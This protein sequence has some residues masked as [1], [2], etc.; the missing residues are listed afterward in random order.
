MLDGS[1]LISLAREVLS[2]LGNRAEPMDYLEDP[3]DDE[4]SASNVI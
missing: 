2:S 3:S 1:T 4:F